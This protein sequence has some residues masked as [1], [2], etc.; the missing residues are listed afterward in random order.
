MAPS[1][2]LTDQICG[3]PFQ[4][5]SVLPSKICIIPGGTGPNIVPASAARTPPSGAAL[6]ASDASAEFSPLPPVPVVPPS[7]TPPEPPPAPPV[8]SPEEPPTPVALP[9]APTDVELAPERLDAPAVPAAPTPESWS[10][11]A[12]DS[13]NAATKH[14]AF[15][16]ISN[17][18]ANTS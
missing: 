2:R 9:P 10:E 11:Q 14:Q 3:L 5:V 13:A 18:L 12:L 1:A 8:T 6:L 15:R 17:L 16:R 4:P 7:S